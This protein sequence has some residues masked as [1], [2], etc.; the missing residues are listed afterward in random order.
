MFTKT[1][2][3][4]SQEF[5]SLASP[6]FFVAVTSCSSPRLRARLQIRFRLSQR[7]RLQPRFRVPC[8]SVRCLRR[9][10]IPR[11][12]IFPIWSRLRFLPSSLRVF[13]HARPRYVCKD[14]VFRTTGFSKPCIACIFHHHHSTPFAAF[15][16]ATANSIS[17]FSALAVTTPPSHAA[18]ART[19]FAKT[20]YSTPPHFP[21]PAPPAS[22][23]IIPQRPRARPRTRSPRQPRSPSR[24]RPRV[25]PPK[26]P[27]APAG[28]RSPPGSRA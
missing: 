15:T 11:H 12:Q 28:S 8:L 24:R 17:P 3:S 26:S 6:E 25:P 27:S 7:L 22:P 16:Y 18:P 23:A 4:M 13:R 1:L 9:Q 19:M 14:N 21:T 5:S 10:Y 20:L 2:Y